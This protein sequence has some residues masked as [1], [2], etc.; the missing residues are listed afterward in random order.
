[1]SKLDLAMAFLQ[2]ASTYLRT[3]DANATG[4]DDEIANAIDHVIQRIIIYKQEGPT[5]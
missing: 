4:A 3:K 2:I 5:A 1:M